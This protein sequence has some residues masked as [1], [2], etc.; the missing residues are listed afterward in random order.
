MTS[1]RTAVSCAHCGLPVPAGLI[2]PGEDRQF[3]CAACRTV[4]QAIHQCGL[5]SFYS[6]R[7][8][9]DWQ[10]QR[11]QHTDRAYTEFDDDSFIDQHTT[12][13]P[14][15]L[16][17]IELYLEG[18]HCS[19]CV[20]LVEKLPAVASGVIESR[21][22]L[23]RRVAAIVYDPARIELSDLARRLDRLGYPP[24]P[25]HDADAAAIERVENRRHL[26]RI[27]VAGACA[28]NAM[29][30]AIALYAGD[31]SGMADEYR[32]LLRGVSALIGLVALAWPGLVFFR[33]AWSAIRTRTPHMDL[34]IALG[35][36]VGGSAGLINTLR[37]A[38]EV[39][40]D[41]LA[42][43]VL[44]LL[45]GRYMQY[46]QQRRADERLASLFALTPRRARRVQ[47]DDAVDVPVE[48][49]RVGELVAVHAGESIPVD[50]V[51]CDGHGVVDTS[52]MT[53]ESAPVA[54]EPGDGVS[55]GSVSASAR[56]TVRVEA[57][58]DATRLARIARLVADATRDKPRVVQFADRVSGWFVTIAVLAATATFFGWLHVGFTRAA[59]HAAA[60]LIVACP[61]ALGLATPLTLAVSIGRAARRGVLIKSG[62]VLERLARPGVIVL[63]KTG[64]LTHG[65]MTV[66]DWWGDRAALPL[67]AAVE[68][69]STHPVGRA[70]VAA[71]EGEPP[72]ATNV[73]H[74]RSGVVGVV[75][76]RRIVV[77]S[78]R[79]VESQG[80]EIDEQARQAIT[81]ALAE[82]R[83]PTV[84]AADG[85]VAAVASVGDA[86]RDEAPAAVRALRRIGW[87][88][89]IASG[90]HGD[91]VAATAQQVGIP[92][93]DAIGHMTPDDKLALVKRLRDEQPGRAVVMVG[94]GVNDSAA[95]AAASVGL[96]VH[97]GAEAALA[98]A[99]AYFASGGPRR[100]VDLIAA[101]HRTLGTIR[102]TLGVSLAYNVVAVAL[103]S[104]GVI[105]PLIAALLMP[106]S[107]FTVVALA[108]SARTF[109]E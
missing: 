91:V 15:G 36:A 42:T 5:E 87:R 88:P 28:G 54:V 1:E 38:G 57:S 24:H 105:G 50:G 21:L 103:A 47:G 6:V 82:A 62:H 2:E 48:A 29:L 80:V 39:Y 83:T 55:A 40:F 3:C 11:A 4:Y 19:A 76:D 63:D 70:I 95:L 51:V 101:A 107:S 89:I 108:V 79:H 32:H 94:D 65:A 30:A 59:D 23:R 20:W 98:A 73:T 78:R 31:A 92:G 45:V 16:K 7:D 33:G 13:R 61:C 37:G 74:D 77:G 53:G 96:A 35:L 26:V 27:A 12:A 44:L 86:L 10:Q 17:S 14:D 56:L 67:A 97:G 84:I 100:V 52:L 85:C 104:A 41:S 64:T 22:N 81:R 75:G 18:V 90:D 68:A 46:R 99:D 25:L 34:P 69:E 60:L 58:G 93:D 66:T 72:A 9:A 106:L 49:L 8:D 109:D 102:L 71:W 43:L